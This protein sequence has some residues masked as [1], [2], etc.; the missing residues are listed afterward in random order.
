MICPYCK[1][2]IE[3][4]ARFCSECGGE[5]SAN[6]DDNSIT[7]SNWKEEVK[8]EFENGKNEINQSIVE[9]KEAAKEEKTGMWKYKWYRISSVLIIL[10]AIIAFA[11]ANTNKVKTYKRGSHTVENSLR[12]FECEAEA[13][14]FADKHLELNAE[15][16][17][18]NID[19]VT[20][21]ADKYIVYIPVTLNFKFI[22][23]YDFIA[24]L[25]IYKKDN[26][27]YEPK[28]F[29]MSSLETQKVLNN[30]K[31]L[32][33]LIAKDIDVGYES[34]QSTSSTDFDDSE[35]ST[36]FEYHLYKW[37]G[38]D[39]KYEEAIQE[40]DSN[41]IPDIGLFLTTNEG[42][43]TLYEFNCGTGL[44]NHF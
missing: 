6:S 5:I 38:I 33:R 30:R 16:Q 43:N 35:F 12:G 14:I 23:T 2:I 8:K 24:M 11:W 25:P 37:Y 3:D 1:H 36:Y 32:L 44:A 13:P 40:G 7:S 22:G 42:I 17:Y 9:I 26:K 15:M 10:L 41:V 34:Y 27:W 19:G 4:N 29:W 39:L 18:I 20:L 21:V 31:A 28:T